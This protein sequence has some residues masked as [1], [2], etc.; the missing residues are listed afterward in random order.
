[1]AETLRVETPWTYISAMARVRARS[2]RWPRSRAGR[3]EVEIAPDLRDIDLQLAEAGLDGLRLEA[4]GVAFAARRALVR[5][6]AQSLRALD[7]HGVVEQHAHGFGEAVG[8]LRAKMV[9]DLVEQAMV[10]VG[11]GH[12]WV[13]LFAKTNKPIWPSPCH[14]HP[15]ERPS[16]TQAEA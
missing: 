10:A 14:L 3:I 1:M 4:V 15:I 13:V 5:R 16:G 6:S 7:R 2:L 12:F 8:A 11:L 9:H